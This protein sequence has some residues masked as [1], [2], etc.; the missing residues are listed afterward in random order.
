MAISTGAVFVP[1]EQSLVQFYPNDPQSAALETVPLLQLDE[2]RPRWRFIGA[3]LRAG[4]FQPGTPSFQAGQL[5]VALARTVMTWEQLLGRPLERWQ[6][7]LP[8]SVYPRVD[9]RTLPGARDGFNAFYDRESLQFFFDTHPQTG[10]LVYTCE[11]CDISCH[12]AGH[13]V[14]D[15]LHPEFWDLPYAEVAAFHEGF[16]DCSAMLVTLGDSAVRRA[17]LEETGGD[18]RRSNLVSRLAEQLGSAIHD[19]YGPEACP[20][21]ALRDAV[22]D[23]VYSAPES[24]PGSGP[25]TTL[26]REAHSFARVFAGTFYDL[27]AGICGRLNGGAPPSEEMIDVARLEA[28]TLLAQGVLMVTASS[29]LYQGVAQAMQKADALRGGAH[30]DVLTA[31][32]GRRGLLA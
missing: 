11:S 2:N 8:L 25:A 5:Q 24:L 29:R 4:R 14:L 28:G 23:F 22:N 21:N 31:V 3:Q 20:P 17:M 32:F 26:T 9:Y 12:E 16:A 10:A 27:F 30:S 6:S 18:L 13:A 7:G 1:D 15:A 19:A